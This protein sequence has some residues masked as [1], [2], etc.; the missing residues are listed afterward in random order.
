[1][2]SNLGSSNAKIFSFVIQM[3]GRIVIII[4]IVLWEWVFCLLHEWCDNISTSST[5]PGNF[6]HPE[7]QNATLWGSDCIIEP[8]RS[9]ESERILEEFSIGLCG[10]SNLVCFQQESRIICLKGDS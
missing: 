2:S 10:M 7:V 1:M 6:Q 8:F 5:I 3:H 4:Q 9:L